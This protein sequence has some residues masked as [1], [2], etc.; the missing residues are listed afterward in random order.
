MH[1]DKNTNLK[2]YISVD[3]EG[4]TGVIHWDE[5][6]E[7]NP[8]YNYFRKLMT[9]EAN[10]AIEG[11]LAAG[12]QEIWVRD[13]HGTA[14]NLI[15]DELHEQAKLIREWSGGPKGMMELIDE[16][17]DAAICIGYHAKAGTPNATLKHTMS[18]AIL[19]L[20]VN[21]LS[22][23]ELGWN[24]LIAGYYGVPLVFVSGDEAICRQALELIPNIHTVAVKTGVG[25]A[26]VNLHP[27]KSRQLIQTGVQTALE[28]RDQFQPYQLDSPFRFEIY[29]K[30]ENR[31]QRA[32][33]YPGAERVDP[34][35]VALV[36]TD[37]FD[38]LRFYKLCS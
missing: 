7:K 8:D 1:S 31:A 11:A 6:T 10:A 2:V 9:A 35:G 34:L 3:M 27:K 18:G 30:D 17:F 25:S 28:K 19:D 14:R 38:G 12:A 23:P 5:T 33:W 32:S 21:G 24:A 16:S 36:C 4:I 20:R 26:S 15:P 13:A 22:L 29:F 37:F